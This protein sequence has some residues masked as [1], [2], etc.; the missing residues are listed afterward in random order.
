MAEEEDTQREEVASC[1]LLGK[2]ESEEHRAE[3]TSWA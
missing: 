2:A 1:Q 3:S